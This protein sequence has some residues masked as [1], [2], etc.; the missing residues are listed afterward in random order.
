MALFIDILGLIILLSDRQYYRT[1]DFIMKKIAPF[2][3]KIVTVLTLSFSP[4]FSTSILHEEADLPSIK[5][6]M[7][8]LEYS[9][10]MVSEFASETLIENWR[11]LSKLYAHAE[12]SNF[13]ELIEEHHLKKEQLERL[14]D[15]CQTFINSKRMSDQMAFDFEFVIFAQVC[16]SNN[17]SA[18][19]LAKKYFVSDRVKKA[20]LLE[21]GV[22]R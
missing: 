19:D 22:V 1:K 7:S 12:K 6:R 3:L 14:L 18:E 2:I 17:C 11:Q 9:P 13:E 16:F 21:E 15:N 4:S 10:F 5:K 20:Y 8:S